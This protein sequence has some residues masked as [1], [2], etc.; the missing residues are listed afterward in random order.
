VDVFFLEP[1][2]PKNTISLTQTLLGSA[3]SSDRGLN[4]IAWANSPVVSQRVGTLASCPESQ[5]VITVSELSG[6]P[7]LYES[8]P[9]SASGKSTLLNFSLP[10][11]QRKLT[12][13]N[14]TDVDTRLKHAGLTKP[15]RTPIKETGPRDSLEP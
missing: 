13:T 6:R 5:F 7:A 1:Q 2:A 4:Q 10:I 8:Q 15:H 11:P 12:A 14:W 9:M 3:I